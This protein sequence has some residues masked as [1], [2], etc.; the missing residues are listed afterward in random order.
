MRNKISRGTITDG[1]FG[2]GL[3]GL[4]LMRSLKVF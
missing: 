1:E 3:R 2:E 4:L